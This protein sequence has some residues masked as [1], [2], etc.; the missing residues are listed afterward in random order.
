[1]TTLAL[2]MALTGAYWYG[3]NWT[4]AAN[5]IAPVRVTVLGH[6][7]FPGVP[8]EYAVSE[9]VL[10][11]DYMLSWPAWERVAFTWIQG[12]GF[13]KWPRSIS[14]Y[15]PREGGLGFLW[16]LGCLP[17]IFSVGISSYRRRGAKALVY[18]CL[19]MI[20]GVSFI[21]TPAPWRSRYTMWIYAAGLPCLAVVLDRIVSRV[22]PR[23]VA[24]GVLSIA[25]GEGAYA[26]VSQGFA[27]GT[28]DPRHPDPTTLSELARGLVTFDDPIH[29]F[30]LS[31]LGREAVTSAAPVAIGP[32]DGPQLPMLGQLSQPVGARDVVLL[33]KEVA[34]DPEKLA[35]LCA[36][37]HVRWVFWP[38]REPAP[39][40]LLRLSRRHEWSP[41]WHVFELGSD[42]VRA[43][44]FFRRGRAGPLDADGDR[45]QER[46]LRV[47][48][49]RVP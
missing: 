37:R 6:E 19:V 35:E 38:D 5:P 1:M 30:E 20:V 27:R 31:V 43:S 15:D 3:R 33:S 46:L 14:W 47:G 48:R 25:V 23:I 41:L 24:A 49:A 42:S 11:P 8:L 13:G 28:P 32:I 12:F 10:T 18:A 17:A 9:K 44:W 7:L 39:E 36:K 21:V 22:A 16:V 45:S 2:L 34:H 40:S 26:F 29:L 4:H